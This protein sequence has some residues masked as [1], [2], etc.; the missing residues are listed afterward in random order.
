[1]LTG[2]VKWFNDEKGFGFIS[3]EDGTDVFVHYSAIKEEG[4]RKDLSEGQQ[5][6]YDVIE[7][8]KGL[9]A[10]NVQKM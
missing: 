10:S 8:P 2:V 9:Q 6:Q 3:G 7:T 4:K 1:M 5:V